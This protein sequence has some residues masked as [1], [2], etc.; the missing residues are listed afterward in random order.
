VADNQTEQEL[1]KN[2]L[3]ITHG[4]PTAGKSEW[5]QEMAARYP[6]RVVHVN[7]NI[8]RL[9][10]FGTDYKESGFFK[11]H[12]FEINQIKDALMEK[13]WNEGKTVIVSDPNLKETELPALANKARS[14][15]LSF[16]QQYFDIPLEESLRRNHWRLSHGGFH[17]SERNIINM[18]KD[19]VG[20]DSRLKE[21]RIGQKMTFAYDRA[22]SDDERFVNEWNAKQQEKY[23]IRGRLLANFDMDGSLVDTRTISN[24][25]LAKDLR[26]FDAFHKASEFAP[27]NEAVLNDMFKAYE[28]G[29]TISV[30]TA[31]LEAYAGETTR[32][33]E[34]HNAPVSILKHRHEGD[35]RP[36]HDAKEDMI[37]EFR[38]DG[39]E[40]AHSWDDNPSAVA[41]F[42]E[43]G[44]RVTEIPFHA[45]VDPSQ[46]PN[47]YPPVTFAS[48]FDSGLCLRCGQPFK[49]S[50]PLGP[51][52]R[53]K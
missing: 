17:L 41:A 38:R 5:A 53:L 37:A 34:R 26:N 6:D 18:A 28:A 1:L 19:A 20:K 15:G 16:A 4:L 50:G 9:R 42:K 46:E 10:R 43:A 23:P 48:P 13:A 45:P 27:A 14:R 49:G 7:H 11:K 12:E 24:L 2:G 8:I 31:R 21:F 51:K 22:G 30:T 44:V 32:W 33:L 47:F 52:C 40:I 25:Y 35:K 29:F 39:L 36:D 3:I